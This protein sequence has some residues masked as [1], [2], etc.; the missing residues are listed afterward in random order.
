M[1]LKAPP[2]EKAPVPKQEPIPNKV[3]LKLALTNLQIQ[4]RLINT[5]IKVFEHK[6]NEWILAGMTETIADETNPDYENRIDV[7]FYFEKA[8]VLRFELHNFVED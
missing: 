6:N 2:K 7:D 5:F 8:Q 3:E 4:D 1:P